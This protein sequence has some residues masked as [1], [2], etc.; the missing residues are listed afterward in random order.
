MPA[1]LNPGLINEVLQ[2]FPNSRKWKQISC[3][4]LRDPRY[5]ASNRRI[6]KI[7]AGTNGKG[8]IYAFLLPED[9]FKGNYQI[10]LHGPKGRPIKF[11]FSVAKTHLVSGRKF[12]CYVGRATNL[13]KR[14]QWHFNLHEGST[15]SQMRKGLV[16][17]GLCRDGEAAISLI[18]DHATIAWNVLDGDANVAN[19]DIIEISLWG[20]FMP[21]FNIKSEH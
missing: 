18:L 13:L 11:G 8:G 6:W 1:V 14:I 4:S 16:N 12:V 3:E 21:P 7:L 19:R 15:T 5:K 17:C 10:R 20:K 2:S 9:I